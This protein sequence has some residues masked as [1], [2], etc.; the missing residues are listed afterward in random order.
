MLHPPLH[1]PRGF[2]DEEVFQTLSLGN[3]RLDLPLRPPA[4]GRAF[5]E[6]P[7]HNQAVILS[8]SIHLNSTG[9]QSFEKSGIR[10]TAGNFMEGSC[11]IQKLLEA[12]HASDQTALNNCDIFADHFDI[13]EDVAGEKDGYTLGSLLD[14]NVPNLFASDRIQAAQR[15]VQHQ[16]IRSIQQRLGNP[17]SLEHSLENF[18][19]VRCRA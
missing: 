11:R 18:R 9:F 16:E 4:T 5:P 15:F 12:T 17:Q 13:A 2:L 14:Q 8:K 3:H 19:N 10:M 7:L 1:G 6:F